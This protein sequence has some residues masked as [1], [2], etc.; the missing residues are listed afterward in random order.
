MNNLFS[1]KIRCCFQLLVDYSISRLAVSELAAIF[2]FIKVMFL[3]KE[4]LWLQ[5]LKCDY[6]LLFL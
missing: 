4:M 6:L 1:K 2:I 3:T 5:T